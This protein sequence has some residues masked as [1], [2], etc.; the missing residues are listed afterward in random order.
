MIKG[1]SKIELTNVKNGEVKIYENENTITDLF[2]ILPS[3]MNFYSALSKFEYP[4]W[5]NVF[6]GILLFPKQIEEN[7]STVIPA[8]DNQ[9][10][11]CA[12][13]DTNTG[14]RSDKGSFNE[15]ES[16]VQRDGSIKMVWDF[17]TSQ[18]NGN[19]N[20]LALTTGKGGRC[21]YGSDENV[22]TTYKTTVLSEQIKSFYGVKT[23]ATDRPLLIDYDSNKM[24]VWNYTSGKKT[25]LE[26]KEYDIALN[27]LKL[28]TTGLISTSYKTNVI[29][30][31]TTLQALNV[32]YMNTTA[33]GKSYFYFASNVTVEN[34]TK[35][36][37]LEI[38]IFNNYSSK[39]YE[40]NNNTGEK[41]QLGIASS[42]FYTYS[43]VQG[44]YLYCQ[45]NSTYNMYKICLTDSTDV[46]KVLESTSSYYEFMYV[47][48]DFM[49]MVKNSEP[50]VIYNFADDTLKYMND[51]SGMT[52]NNLSQVVTTSWAVPIIINKKESPFFWDINSNSSSTTYEVQ[53]L[54]NLLFTI[55]NLASP[56]IK[57][58]DNTMKITYTL[59]EV[60]N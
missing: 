45:S 32:Y 42:G 8:G 57:T 52:F 11:A 34:N 19:I 13:N 7:K 37:L 18:A 9:P 2:D 26:I 41:L 5:K 3:A 48:G 44:N 6:G 60:N 49:Y 10:F 51:C 29:Q 38:D 39:V 24:F 46:T 55:N 22:T 53:F 20:A 36:Y 4:I 23:T 17:T 27:K 59:T 28:N 56:I 31:N 35:F 54:T 1:K 16:M 30:L 47:I 21:G 12:G 14:T 40:L 33:N 43:R 50:L 25:T 58:A 15:T